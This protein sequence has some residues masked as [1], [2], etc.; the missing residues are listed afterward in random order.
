ME[1]PFNLNSI[2][3]FLK[4]NRWQLEKL[5]E[6][7]IA[8][9]APDNVISDFVLTLPRKVPQD[10]DM[11]LARV[12]ETISS[13]Y[14]ISDEMAETLFS[15]GDTN[16]LS[17]QISDE[18]TSYGSIPF[19]VFEAHIQELRRMLLHNA[20]FC[21]VNDALGVDVPEEAET[22]LNNCEFLQTQKGSFVS[23]IRLPEGNLV[24]PLIGVEALNSQA[25]NNKLVD[26]LSFV[27][28]KVTTGIVSFDKRA[29][30]QNLALINVKLFTD[31]SNL[32]KRT[33]A[34]S[35]NFYYK[36]EQSDTRAIQSGIVDGAAYDNLDRYINFVQDSLSSPVDID[37]WGKVVE[38]KSHDVNGQR[39]YIVINRN[40]RGVLPL[41]ISSLNNEQ[42]E[43][44]L[45]AH[46]SSRQVHIAGRALQRKYYLRVF[47]ITSLS[48]RV[49]K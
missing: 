29:I 13:L 43:T 35:I 9:R 44:A 23:R 15:E 30:D 25:I 26:V 17:I 14:D 42:Y 41:H 19:H 6:K 31:I 21:I 3:G 27:F 46:R 1:T 39:N 33:N 36:Q 37:S 32:L 49:K 38:L 40:G 11:K 12:V 4:G 5:N 10:R 45:E 16:T 24:A 2:L 8:Y 22:Y 48:M 28:E 47:E 20:S 34:E 7:F 18:I